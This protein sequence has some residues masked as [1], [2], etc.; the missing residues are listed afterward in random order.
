M[1]TAQCVLLSAAL[2]LP[3]AASA[4]R[5]PVPADA[6]PSFRAECG[7]C[8]LPF[9]PAL[10]SAPDWRRVMAQLDRHYGDNAGLDEETRR[11][12][13]AFLLR[14]AG[15]SRVAGAGDPP[16]LTRTDWFR[17]EHRKVPES[18]WRDARVMSASNCA[19]CHSRAGEGS[20]RGR[21]LA[22]PELRE[23]H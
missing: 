6:P 8:H 14:H 18:I 23:R 20:Y 4:D 16:R 10:L 21:E 19:A 15:G 1:K 13:E 22:L 11:Q 3:A 17:R 9:A 2:L 7:G 5:L 12:I